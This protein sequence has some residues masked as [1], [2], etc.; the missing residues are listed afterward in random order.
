MQHTVASLIVL[1]RRAKTALTIGE[2]H[3]GSADNRAHERGYAGG[4][5]VQDGSGFLPPLRGEHS[6][7]DS[8][9]DLPQQVMKT[10][11]T[12]QNFRAENKRDPHV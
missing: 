4:N 9:D 8:K 5:E 12:A 10:T 6:S 11:K 2:D 1:H 7:R 3:L